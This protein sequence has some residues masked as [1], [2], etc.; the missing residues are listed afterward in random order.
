MSTGIKVFLFSGTSWP[1]G[2]STLFPI[3]CVPASLS[4]GVKRPGHEADHAP[5]SSAELKNE[6]SY[7]ST[8]RYMPSQ[9]GN[10]QWYFYFM[11]NMRRFYAI[12]SR[13]HIV[14]R[15]TV[16]KMI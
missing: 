6:W 4:Q 8:R 3:Q 9:L 15:Y 13:M 10:G 2:G 11:L 14:C 12:A 7:V 1:V 5:R 16:A